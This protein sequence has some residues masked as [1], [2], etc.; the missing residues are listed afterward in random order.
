MRQRV[1]LLAILA[2]LLAFP[3]SVAA[4]A[5]SGEVFSATLS[6]GAEVPA[7]STTAS[8]SAWFVISPDASTVTYIVQYSGLSGPATAAHIH[9]GA[10]N[11]SGGVMLPL[12][13]GPSPMVGTI[14]AANLVAT[15]GVS[16]FAG[17]LDAIR[18]GNTY[19]NIH[20]AANP[21]GEIRGQLA[22]A[23][24]A[25]AFQTL[26]AGSQE[27]PAVTGGGS[28][29]ATVIVNASADTLTYAVTYTGMTSAPSAGH[30][31]LG[32]AGANGG[33]MLPFASVG[34]SPF[35]GTLTVSNLVPTGSVTTFPQAVDAI[36]AGNT[37][38]N[39][40]TAAHPGGEVRGQ[41]GVT[42][43]APPPATPAP[44]ATPA[45]PKPTA[46]AAPEITVPPTSTSE[47][48]PAAPSDLALLLFTVLAVLAVGGLAAAFLPARR[49]RR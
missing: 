48:A 13:A 6:G 34:T 39:L 23:T 41:L 26:L 37:Y 24:G 38:V 44:T 7:V 11:V 2:G 25:Q 42:V 35:V 32:A 40:H 15:G 36:R 1:A 46:T 45:A 3:G 22:A 28:G 10:A 31:H 12:V 21:A 29:M 5:T 27:V 19:V 30:I 14:T 33:V 18:A 49:W 17:A 43:A 20:T 9:L 8:G 47:T 16:T 4:A